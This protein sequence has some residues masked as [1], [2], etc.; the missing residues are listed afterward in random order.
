MPFVYFLCSIVG[1][2]LGEIIEDLKVISGKT[3]DS[4]DHKAAEAL[5]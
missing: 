1:Y 4:T 3:A 5:K 2:T